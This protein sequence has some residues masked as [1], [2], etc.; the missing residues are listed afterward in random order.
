MSNNERRTIQI[1]PDFLKLSGGGTRKNRKSK[2]SN[3]PDKPI[4]IKTSATDKKP[5]VS[6]LKKNIL[7]MIRKHQENKNKTEFTPSSTTDPSVQKF[8]SEFEDSIQFLSSLP[9]RDKEIVNSSKNHT[10]RNLSSYSN[11]SYPNTSYPN[12]SFSSNEV[13]LPQI[14][15]MNQSPFTP[16]FITPQYGCLKNGSLPTYRIWK[17]KT[18]RQMPTLTQPNPNMNQPVYSNPGIT[19]IVPGIKPIVK[20]LQEVILPTD[21]TYE[22]KLKKEIQE[23]TRLEQLKIKQTPIQTIGPCRN[24]QKRILRRTYRVGKSKIQPRISVLVSNKTLRAQTSLKTQELKQTP[25]GDVKKY[26]LKHGFI[27][28]GTN[29]PPDVLRKMY[30]TAKLICGEIHNHNPENLLYNYFN[31]ET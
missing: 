28:I 25:I 3:D 2:V 17:N 20:P 4:K 30:E 8:N 23:L 21:L 10:I 22:E 7:N 29:S 13:P 19:P 11:T 5:N 31:Q 16:V 15:P 1:N 9:K 24:R 27:K 26:L 12:T 14:Q 6:T 18:Q